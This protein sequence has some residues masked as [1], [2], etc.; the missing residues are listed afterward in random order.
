L[1]DQKG[2]AQ[3]K[4]VCAFMAHRA[5]GRYFRLLKDG[6]IKIDRGKIREEA[7]LDGK[8]IISTSDNT[9]APEDIA[10]GYKQLLEVERA[11]QTLKTTKLFYDLY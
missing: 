3:K 6:A 5:M 1:G 11:F 8:D 2:K 7:Q 4:S 9:L 10:L